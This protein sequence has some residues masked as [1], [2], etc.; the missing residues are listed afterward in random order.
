MKSIDERISLLEKKLKFS[1]S[2]TS[3]SR[4]LMERV[5]MDRSLAVGHGIK[6]P[7][8]KECILVWGLAIGPLM[9]PKRFFYDVTIDGVI[10]KAEEAAKKARKR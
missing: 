4:V 6:V 5:L 7:E 9:E 1:V 10:K 2:G 8:R 3:L